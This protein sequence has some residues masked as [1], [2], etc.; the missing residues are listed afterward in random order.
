MTNSEKIKKQISKW[1]LKVFYTVF[2]NEEYFPKKIRF[3]KIKANETLKNYSAIRS[4]ISELVR[5]S[6]KNKGYGY[7]IEFVSRVDK[8][9]GQ[10]NFPDK[11]IIPSLK[12]YLKLINKEKEFNSFIEDAK[13]MIEKMPVLNEWIVDHI[14]EI[15][16]NHGQWRDL[17]K[18]CLYFMDNPEPEYYIRELPIEVHT[19]FIEDNKIILRSLLDFLI[20]DHINKD[21]NNF[22]KRF[23]LKYSQPLIRIKVLD[24]H[25]AKES[26]SGLTDLT[27]TKSEFEKMD[28]DCRCVI[29]LEN[30]TN[31]SNIYNFLTL[32]QKEKSISIF[33][34]G[35][36]V[37]LLKD[38]NWMK[39]IEIYYWGDIDVH[40]F[41][42]LSQ[43]RGYFP[44]VKSFLM[45]EETFNK[46]NHFAVK[47]SE[48]NVASL[49]NLTDEEEK[50]YRKLVIMK[51]KNRLEQ[52]RIGHDYVLERMK[53]INI[54]LPF[55][56][57]VK[58]SL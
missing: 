14:R 56:N 54:L 21:E 49:E 12:D 39:K 2:K 7:E 28:I 18:V 4:E 29:I 8:K 23:N 36:S 1:Y 41:Q 34:K 30:K 57:N 33:G 22:E 40:G 38:S 6:K 17:L 45:D 20:G 50:F 51:D 9:I 19:K 53:F 16:D 52:E 3:G 47:G 55:D 24:H 37:G 25:I 26:F 32:P 15:I 5:S 43:I 42:I 35:F 10:Q 58:D 11:I 44:Q 46:Y 13:M 48:S 27:I 31:F